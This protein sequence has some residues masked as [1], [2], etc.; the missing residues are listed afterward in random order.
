MKGTQLIQ[1]SRLYSAGCEAYKQELSM[2]IFTQS[3]Q[4]TFNVIMDNYVGLP[5]SEWLITSWSFF[6]YYKVP[7]RMARVL[8]LIQWG[9]F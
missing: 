4:V 7:D 2:K 8:L 9:F 6:L 1:Q 5:I 3:C